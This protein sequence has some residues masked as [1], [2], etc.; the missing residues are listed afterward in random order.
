M[1]GL[2]LLYNDVKTALLEV[3]EVKDVAVYNSQD[4]SVDDELHI[5]TPAVYVSFKN[6]RY[7]T[8]PFGA[9]NVEGDM[10]LKVCQ[11]QYAPAEMSI[12]E[13][14]Q[15]INTK[16]HKLKDPAD[17][18]SS[19]IRTGGTQNENWKG[20]ESFDLWYHFIALEE[21]IES[22]REYTITEI[23]TTLPY[24]HEIIE[25]GGHETTQAFDIVDGGDEQ[26]IITIHIQ[27]G[28]TKTN[29]F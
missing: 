9:Q 26:P 15:I 19:L 21:P 24:A 1:T 27:D 20:Y 28:N 23:E 8:L 25:D 3:P 29:P 18:Y 2:A 4:V 16:I 13:L 7:T 6:L 5:I 11:H 17:R 14:C 12:Y 22:Y 10:W